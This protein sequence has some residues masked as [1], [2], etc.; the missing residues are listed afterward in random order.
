ME[1]DETIAPANIIIKDYMSLLDRVRLRMAPKYEKLLLMQSITGH[2][3]NGHCEFAGQAYVNTTLD[4]IVDALASIGDQRIFQEIG[5][6][7]KKNVKQSRDGVIEALKS[8]F[9]KIIEGQEVKSLTDEE[10]NP[11][12]GISAL[13]EVDIKNKEAFLIGGYL[14][15][16]MDCYEWRKESQTIMV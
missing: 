15:S 13:R 9:K 12:L 16:K 4:E 2:A 5:K 1:P 14:A 7:S 6:V 10:G 3:Q 11:L 8:P